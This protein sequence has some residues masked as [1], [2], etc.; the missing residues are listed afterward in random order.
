MKEKDK[1]MWKEGRENFGR[2]H[3]MDRGHGPGRGHGGHRGPGGMGGFDRDMD[4]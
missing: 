1:E 2:G 4:D 3:G